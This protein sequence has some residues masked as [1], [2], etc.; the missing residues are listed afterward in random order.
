MNNK[1]DVAVMGFGFGHQADYGGALAAHEDVRLVGVAERPDVRDADAIQRG[2][3]FA[4]KHGVPYYSDYRE[5]L[6][7]TNPLAVSLAVE[8]EYNVDIAIELATRGTSIMCEKPIAVSLS[9]ADRLG[10]VLKETGVKFTFAAPATVFSGSFR[11]AI[12]QIRN[13]AIGKARVGHFQYLQP[14]GPQFTLSP[15]RCKEVTRAELANFGPYGVLAFLKMFG[16]PIKSVFARKQAAFYEQYRQN[17]LDDLTLMSIR[18]EDGAIGT[19]LIGRTTTTGLASTDLR[20]QVIGSEG[21]INIEDGLGY[22][23]DL[24]ADK[25]HRKLRFGASVSKLFADDFVSAVRDNRQPA[26]T[27]QDARP[28]MSFIDAAYESADTGREVTLS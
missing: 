4:E 27:F 14:N 7:S 5:M 22:A 8:A 21:V 18:F 6:K 15:E 2:R 10:K 9:E 13:G 23:V 17:N 11:P 19:M 16:S 1:L 26:I 24:Y 12:E 28:V 3:D 25:A 20:M